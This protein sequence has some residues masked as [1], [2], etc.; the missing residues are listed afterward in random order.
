MNPRDLQ[1]KM[2]AEWEAHERTFLSWP[3]QDSMCF[4]QDYDTVCAGYAELIRAIAEFEPVTVVVNPADLEQISALFNEDNVECLPIPHNDAWLRDN[5]P[6]FVVNEQGERAGINWRFNAWGGKYEPWDLDDAVAPSILQQLEMRRF[7]APLVMEGG[8]L[9]VDGEGTLITTEE[10][11]LN[12]NRNPELDREQIEELVKQ[13]VNV[14]NIIWLK[15]GLAGDETDGHVDNIAC[16][17]APGTIIVQVCEDPEDENYAITQDNLRT[18]S[19]AVDARGRKLEL[20]LIQQPPAAFHEGNRL[21][22]SYLNF[23]FVNNGI[24]LPVFGG[25]AEHTDLLAEQAL[26]RAFPDRRVRTINGMAI[27][28]EGGNVHCTTQQLPAGK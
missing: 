1:Y 28:R 16:F 24:I 6:T 5:G 8:S 18:L 20:I 13:Y 14:E 3:V 21:T 9:H 2:P 23:Y 19:E 25:A 22:L 11:L 17:A 7:D 4:P 12:K 27:I 10:C 15:R 26:S